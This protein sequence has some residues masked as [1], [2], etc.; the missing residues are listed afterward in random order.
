MSEDNSS[1]RSISSTIKVVS[2]LTL[3][4]QQVLQA[5][6]DSPSPLTVED[7]GSLLRLHGNTIRGVL[8]TLLELGLASRAA[9]E[10]E[11]R[12]R[13]SWLYEAKASADTQVVLEGYTSLISALA[14]Q[15]A[16]TAEDPSASAF[17]LGSHWGQKLLAEQEA[18]G[19]TGLS[20]L[21]CTRDFS[22]RM[23]KV[24]IFLSR[25]G[26][27]A[28][29]GNDEETIELHQCPLLDTQDKTQYPLVCQIH[30]GMLDQVVRES[31]RGTLD[32]SVVP[33]AGPGFCTVTLRQRE[34]A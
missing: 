8:N 19:D 27:Q 1:P 7:L 2:S 33:N 28:T 17:R 22:L 23:A 14:D 30:S 31:S 9:E 26:F 6:A 11:K 5:L 3:T 15:I 18:S 24:R 21:D 25:L 20:D 12:G 29:E 34:D 16:L 4:Q 32:V 10:T 13:P